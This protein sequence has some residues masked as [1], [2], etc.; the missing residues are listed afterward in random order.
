MGEFATSASGPPILTLRVTVRAPDLQA[1]IERYSK[2]ID[3]D[4]I[5]IFT[6]N[7]Q[8]VGTRV[9]FTLQ[10]ASGEQLIH[11]K[12]TVT[13]VQEDRGDRHHPPGMELVYVPLGDRSQTL[14]DFLLATRESDVPPLVH[15]VAPAPAQPPRLP[16]PEIGRGDSGGIET[17]DA[18]SPPKQLA[19]EVTSSPLGA[20]V[21]IEGRPHAQPTPTRLD[22]LDPNKTYEVEFTLKGFCP[23]RRTLRPKEGEKLFAM[24]TRVE[25]VVEVSSNPLGAEL[26][27]DGERMG[28][29]P[30]TVRRL[31]HGK[32]HEIEIR[33]TGYAPQKRRI[34]PAEV[35][36]PQGKREVLA[37]AVKLEPE[38]RLVDKAAARPDLPPPS[39]ISLASDS[40]P[41]AVKIAERL[42]VP[43]N[44]AEISTGLAPA[45]V[46]LWREPLPPGPPAAAV[47]NNVPANPFSDVSDG[48]IEYFVEW[49][50]EQSIGTRA[51]LTARFS[52]VPMAMPGSDAGEPRPGTATAEPSPTQRS[53]W[54]VGAFAAGIACG[55]LAMWIARPSMSRGAPMQAPHVAAAPTIPAPANA[56]QPAAA[57]AAE[58]ALTVVTRPPGATVL[59]D[60]KPA[61]ESP[62][63]ARVI[64][65]KH[66]ITASKERYV[67]ATA[68]VEA[69]GTARLSLERP[70]ATL[71]IV[72]TPPGAQV[73]I[74]GAVRGRTPA[75]IK[76]PAFES[77]DVQ[78]GLDGSKPW[79]RSV[80]LRAPSRNLEVRLAPNRLSPRSGPSKAPANVGRTGASK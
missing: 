33:L 1:F 48:A 8:P 42:P 13:R 54:M 63:A 18:S 62:I 58:V 56:P 2:H 52:N 65:G 5:F 68:T 26:F 59:I 32:N 45:L 71:R 17:E 53:P 76:L 57:P 10:L 27:L 46:E 70:T 73:A 44:P 35:F 15:T 22:R 31:P 39:P 4:R 34:S 30:C 19:I 43:A 16:P 66:H 50:L 74:S 9:Q 80:Y 51:E 41:I 49:S 38:E 23:S 25:R 69:P 79:R 55:V 6:K 60:G 29:T 47:E 40:V 37:L 28:M 3:G 14:V 64:V 61:G 77:Y 12:G 24:L 75:E 7:P 72:S 21:T 20:R 78:L 36:D 11:G 67:T